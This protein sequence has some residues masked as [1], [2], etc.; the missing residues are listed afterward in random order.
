MRQGRARV[1]NGKL[2]CA[3]AA[4][5]YAGIGIKKF[6]LWW[7]VKYKSSPSKKPGNKGKVLPEDE[8]ALVNWFQ[9]SCLLSFSATELQ[10]VIVVKR[11]SEACGISFNTKNG[12]PSKRWLARFMKRNPDVARKR[13]DALDCVRAGAVNPDTLRRHSA[14]CS[15]CT[16]ST[17]TTLST[18][19][20]QV[21]RC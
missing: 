3:A 12:F 2:L 21:S 5:E 19:T 18:R 20:S 14:R 16:V 4:R 17:L 1:L 13:K 15:R 6:T 9:E 10:I 11:I 7:M 8:D